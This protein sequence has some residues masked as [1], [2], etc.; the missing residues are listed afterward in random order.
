MGVKHKTHSCPLINC[1][2]RS[3]VHNGGFNYFMLCGSWIKHENFI[4]AP[5][6]I[7]RF[8]KQNF[9]R[10]VRPP[11]RHNGRSDTSVFTPI[12]TS[13]TIGSQTFF[14]S[15]PQ[16][17]TWLSCVA[18]PQT[19][20]TR[21]II[22]IIIYIIYTKYIIDIFLYQYHQ[23]VLQFFNISNEKYKWRNEKHRYY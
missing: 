1:R 17:K 19:K 21:N 3:N 7:D 20:L 22:Y 16:A 11:H 9:N 6:L 5:S 2:W 23:L 13:Y 8:S 12:K 15:L 4:D 18:L 10:I 14:V